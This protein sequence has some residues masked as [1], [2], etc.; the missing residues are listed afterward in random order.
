MTDPLDSEA[1]QLTP[2]AVDETVAPKHCNKPDAHP[3]HNF[4]DGGFEGSPL[5]Y[6]SGERLL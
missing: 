1:T 5:W 4:Q 6:C 3:A 2:Q